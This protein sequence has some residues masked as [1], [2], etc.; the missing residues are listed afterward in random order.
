MDKILEK[1]DELEQEIK[2]A[3]ELQGCPDFQEGCIQCEW[4]KA[5]DGVKSFF[6]VQAMERE[7]TKTTEEKDNE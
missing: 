2:D 3:N 6:R 5:F 1:F 4:W 7:K